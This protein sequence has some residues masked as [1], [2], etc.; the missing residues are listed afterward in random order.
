MNTSLTWDV[1]EDEIITL[2]TP[3]ES[4]NQWS[5]PAPSMPPVK[6][7]PTYPPQP[8]SFVSNDARMKE[9]TQLRSR[10]SLSENVVERATASGLA[11][12]NITPETPSR[13]VPADAVP[14]SLDSDFKMAEKRTSV[15]RNEG[16]A[17][18]RA[19]NRDARGGQVHATR[20]TTMHSDDARVS[21][22]QSSSAA[23]A[24]VSEQCVTAFGAPPVVTSPAFSCRVT[25]DDFGV[26]SLS[27]PSVNG[28]VQPE[29]RHTERR[30]QPEAASHSSKSYFPT[31]LPPMS[32]PDLTW[33]VPETEIVTLEPISNANP[34]SQ[35]KGFKTLGSAKVELK[36]PVHEPSQP[37]VSP[38]PKITP[39]RPNSEA[40]PP[41]EPLLASINSTTKGSG[42]NLA[43]SSHPSSQISPHV[44]VM[45]ISLARGSG[46]PFQHVLIVSGVE[47]KIH[48]LNEL[49]LTH[50]ARAIIHTGNFGFYDAQSIP[51]LPIS[52]LRRVAQRELGLEAVAKMTDAAII[53]L[54]SEQSLLS[55]L[56]GYCHGKKR[57]NVPV[58]VVSGQY[59]DHAV[60]EKLRKGFYH[61]PNLYILD[62]RHSYAISSE[63][64][65]LRLFGIGG[66]FSYS[67]LFDVGSGNDYIC[68]AKG[69]V[70]VS[71]CQLGELLEL[72]EQYDEPSEIRVFVTQTSPSRD[73][74]VHSIA[75]HLNADYTVSSS[76]I[77]TGCSVYNCKAVH[78]EASLAA[79]VKA[80][81]TDI[82]SLWDQIYFATNEK[83]TYHTSSI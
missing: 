80:C 67:Q 49:A 62:H 31:M 73:P 43:S 42:N 70:W 58:Y 82:K 19:T 21:H 61:V 22:R 41:V 55:E 3:S 52:D 8:R 23:P 13:Q 53:A 40:L 57:L 45:P 81:K 25:D 29:L 4:S 59:E 69:K 17:A 28:S 34:A 51:R 83:F 74:L 24:S 14:P 38:P 16:D 60:V 75:C 56:S 44:S 71:M 32:I 36:K 79:S 1:P 11:T 2:A 66:A 27:Q 65:T 54:V 18:P 12:L 6:E 46:G 76:A 15:S 7:E 20:K 47:G 10:D 63:E 35:T 68:G 64:L 39:K 37:N 78:S 26:A 72:A 33:N 50:N 5:L 9:R 77:T 30:M 48:L